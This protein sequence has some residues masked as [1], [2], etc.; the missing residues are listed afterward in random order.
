MAE[1]YVEREPSG[2]EKIAKSPELLLDLINRMKRVL[3]EMIS[4][5]EKAIEKENESDDIK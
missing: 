5:L 2:K 4:W 3:E 1:G